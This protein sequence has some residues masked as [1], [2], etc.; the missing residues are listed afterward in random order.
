MA[1]MEAAVK[2]LAACSRHPSFPALMTPHVALLPSLLAAPSPFLTGNAALVVSALAFTP[3]LPSLRPTV[4]PLL[5]VMRKWSGREGKGRAEA[6]NNAAVA[7]ARLAKDGNN[8]DV[9]RAHGGMALLA[10]AGKKEL[11]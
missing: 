8:L 6:A 1:L 3:V 7:C 9:I 11:R 2:L 10:S 5:E 4:G